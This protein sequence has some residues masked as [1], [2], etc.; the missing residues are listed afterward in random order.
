MA[1]SAAMRSS[2]HLGHHPHVVDGD[3][4]T[5][6]VDHEQG[7]EGRAG[8]VHPVQAS[9]D[10]GPGLVEVDER[11]VAQKVGHHREEQTQPAAG[12]GR[13]VLEGTDGDRDA[14]HVIEQL[15]ETLVGQVLVDGEVDGQRPHARSVAGGS[16]GLSRW[17]GLGLAPTRAPAAL[18]AVLDDV[19]RIGGSSNTWR[20]SVSTTSASARSAPQRE[21]VGDA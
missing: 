1:F 2:S 21:Q 3:A 17:L 18:H 6:A 5:S 15:G 19:G 10:P 13:H 9:F 7:V 14:E 8:D 4:P 16:S 11:G 12:L 20:R